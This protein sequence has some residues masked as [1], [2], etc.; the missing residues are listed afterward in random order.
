MYSS[1]FVCVLL[2]LNV[3]R[4]SP[5]VLYAL[6]ITLHDALGSGL[7]DGQYSSVKPKGYPLHETCERVNSSSLFIQW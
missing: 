5:R 3:L 6:G 1:F 4:R 7:L 2:L